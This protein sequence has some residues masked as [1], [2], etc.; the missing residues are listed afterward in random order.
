MLLV[1]LMGISVYFISA[2]LIMYIA[3]LSR[4]TI[5]EVSS[6]WSNQAFLQRLYEQG[7]SKAKKYED[8]GNTHE[9]FQVYQALKE[10]YSDMA[11]VSESEA[12]AAQIESNPAFKMKHE[13][14][15]QALEEELRLIRDRRENFWKLKENL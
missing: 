10:D 2:W 3:P 11:E 8:S 1:S 13:Q 14:K 6:L 5:I 4:F 9:A 12:R 7:L 15:R